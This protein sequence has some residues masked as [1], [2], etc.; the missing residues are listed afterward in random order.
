MRFQWFF[1]LPIRIKLYAIV[2]AATTLAL[3]LATTASFILQ[4]QLISKQLHDELRSLAVIIGETAGAGIMFEDK[5]TLSNILQAALNT[6]KHIVTGRLFSQDGSLLSVYN[7]EDFP[8]EY[9]QDFEDAVTSNLEGFQQ[10]NAVILLRLPVV[11]DNEPI[12]HILIAADLTEY[13]LTLLF[14]AILMIGVLLF[15][16]LLAML[17]SSRLLRVIVE[18]IMHLTR[19]VNKISRKQKYDVRAEVLS[20][21]ELG[22]LAAGFNTMIER[23]QVRDSILE[24]QVAERTRDLEQRHL[25]LIEAKDRAEAANLAKSRFL[26]NMS[27][28]IRTPMNA[29]IGMT[30]LAITAKERGQQQRFLATVRHSAENLLGV[31]N[32]ILDF[33]KIEAGQLQ[34]NC[35]PFHLGR[36]LDNIVATMRS[37]AEEKGLV[38]RAHAAPTLPRTVVGDDFRLHQILIN[39]VGNA[40]KFTAAG[41]VTIQVVT[42]DDQKRTDDKIRLH[43]SVIDT[44][45]G[46]AEHKKEDIFKCFEQADSSYAREFGGTGLGL[47]IARQLTGLMGGTM[48]VESVEHQGSIFHFTVACDVWTREVAE[49]MAAVEDAADIGVSGRHILVVDD[50]EVNRDIASITLEQRYQVSTAGNGLESLERLATLDIDLVLMDVQMPLMDGLAT[51][52]VIRACEQGVALDCSLPEELIAALQQRLT[53]AHVPIVAMTA[54]AMAEDRQ[55]CLAAGMDGYITKPFLPDQLFQ[56][57]ASFIR[58]EASSPAGQPATG[59]EQT[60]AGT[61]KEV[62]MAG[63]N[64]HLQS[65]TGL[66]ASQISRLLIAIQESM[67]N[68]LAKMEEAFAADDVSTLAVAAHTLKG[69]LLQC[70]LNDLAAVAEQIHSRARHGDG[71]NDNSKIIFLQQSLADIL[72]TS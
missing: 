9:Q 53:G 36:F 71:G 32:D 15:G 16:L 40:I 38:L 70:G 39:L 65:S 12:G 31:L 29:I 43:F 26:A 56:E 7:S 72:V 57:V 18:P 46:I 37:S 19:L 28:E 4:H 3:L 27:H 64:G 5:G 45:I 59:E 61:A 17:L 51:T 35:R 22:Q 63:I 58:A 24:E 21:D 30:H 1:Q 41:S 54:H 68:N 42:A 69:T 23:I 49:S 25:Q 2:L 48:W 8:G 47:A 55:M 33:S 60:A 34:L 50:N 44:G 67:R 52:A 11:H 14:M 6:K 62:S 10:N 13:R 66:T 20:Q